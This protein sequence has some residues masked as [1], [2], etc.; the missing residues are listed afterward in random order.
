MIR[1]VYGLPAW[2]STPSCLRKIGRKAFLPLVWVMCEAYNE[3]QI[4][5]GKTGR[6]SLARNP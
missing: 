1:R 6:T 2:K 5:K 4:G 3:V